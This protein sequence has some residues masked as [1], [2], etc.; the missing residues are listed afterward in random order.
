MF[1][2]WMTFCIFTGCATELLAGN[3]GL[4]LPLLLIIA[5]YFCSL[6]SWPQTFLPLM[7]AAAAIDSLYG[8]TIPSH[9]IA[10]ATT[11]LL[12][13]GWKKFGDYGTA[14]PLLLPGILVGIIA[15]FG[16]LLHVR[17]Q[18]GHLPAPFWRFAAASLAGGTLLLP[19]ACRLLDTVAASLGMAQLRHR[20]FHAPDHEAFP[21]DYE[22]YD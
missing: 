6:R 2:L 5:F 9:G 1:W 12:A 8:R 4:P 22:I 16:S 17:Q 20:R 19:P 11:L 15:T 3:Y 14:L 10:V 21:E 18:A 7:L 13:Q